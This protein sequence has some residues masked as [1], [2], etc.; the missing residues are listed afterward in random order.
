MFSSVWTG[1]FFLLLVLPF[2]SCKSHPTCPPV[3]TVDPAHDPCNLLG[4]VPNNV[5][6]TIAVGETFLLNEGIQLLIVHL[7]LRMH[8]CLSSTQ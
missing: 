8:W 6:T 4:Y 7:Q 1:L 2:A 3:G 5:L